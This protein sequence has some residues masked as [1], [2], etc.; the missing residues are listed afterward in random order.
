MTD[1]DYALAWDF[2]DPTDGKPRQ[3]RFRQN[4]APP[5]DPRIWDGTGQL[6]AVVA[7]ARR[8]DNGDE[9][10]ISRPDVLLDD[11]EAALEGWQD[12]A[13]LHVDEYDIDRTINLGTIRERIRAAG[14]T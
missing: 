14:L 3:L 4:Y 8:P 10:P 1:I 7:D 9:I 12:W 5:D 6:I 11:V 2:I 13:T